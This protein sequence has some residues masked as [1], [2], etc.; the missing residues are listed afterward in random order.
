VERSLTVV[1][2]LGEVLVPSTGVLP[3]LAAEIGVPEAR[4]GPAYWTARSDYDRGASAAVYWE[5]V[6][7]ALGRGPDPA[8]AERLRDLDAGKWSAL[9]DTGRELLDAAAA[10]GRRLG[11][12]SNAPAPLAAAV[13]AAPWSSAVDV[14][15]FSADV[16]LVKP[17]PEIYARADAAYG[18]RPS[19]V[20]F[21]DDRGDNVAAARA[22]GWDAHLFTGPGSV[23]EVLH[24]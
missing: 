15:V 9:P 7:A 11:L 19:D 14:L 4:L 8:L 22:H 5:G 3:V 6:L 16:G 2:D 12:L 20:V 1:F 24:A 10:T 21:F 13:R 23:L 18:T 17:E